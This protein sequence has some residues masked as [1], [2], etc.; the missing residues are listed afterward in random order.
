M[1][2]PTSRRKV[3]LI[4]TDGQLGDQEKAEYAVSYTYISLCLC[5][6]RLFT[7]YL[8]VTYSCICVFGYMFNVVQHNKEVGRNS[9]HFWHWTSS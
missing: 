2:R 6:M 4:V 7:M 3:L 9:C 1:A 5:F 8:L